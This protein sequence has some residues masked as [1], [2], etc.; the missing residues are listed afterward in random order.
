MLVYRPTALS[1]MGVSGLL[2][3]WGVVGIR[4][5]MGF[6]CVVCLRIYVLR[7]VMINKIR[8]VMLIKKI[9]LVIINDLFCFTT[10]RIQ[11]GSL[12]YL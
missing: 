2:G 7:K 9:Y 12:K 11:N 3:G 1:E 4:G 8:K 10:K 5:W 6:F